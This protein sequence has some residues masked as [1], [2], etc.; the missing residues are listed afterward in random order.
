MAGRWTTGTG[1]SVIVI[2]IQL[3]P[4]LSR[5]VTSLCTCIALLYL[6]CYF[7]VAVLSV[8]S[9]LCVYELTCSA[10]EQCSKITKVYFI[11]FHPQALETAINKLMVPGLS[12]TILGFCIPKFYR[13]TM[14]PW[15]NVLTFIILINLYLQQFYVQLTLQLYGQSASQRISQSATKSVSQ[16]EMQWHVRINNKTSF[17]PQNMLQSKMQ[18]DNCTTIQFHSWYN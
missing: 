10:I 4:P 13:P 3:S 14:L 1:E 9:L 12:S 5:V 2:K 7:C 16:Q 8:L 15:G 11:A 6:S 18:F 17:I